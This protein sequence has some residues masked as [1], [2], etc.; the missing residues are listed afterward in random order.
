MNSRKFFA[1]LKRRNVYKVAVAYAIVS[2]LLI[3]AASILFPTFE[4]PPWVMKVFVAV[5][6][7]GF[8]IALVFSWA[9]E[10]TPEGIKREEDVAPNESITRRTGRKIAGITI[11][12]AA[13]A[14]GLVVFQLLRPSLT[15]KGS[16]PAIGGSV[17][18]KSIAVLPF[19]NLSEDKA[20][21]YFASGM[22]DMILTKLAAIGDLK[23]ISRTST[24]RYKSHP[25]DLKT[26]AQQLGVATVLEGSVQKAGEQVL[27]NVQLIDAANDQHLWAD[28]YPRT[29]DNIFGV[30]GEVAEKVA[31]A[32]KAKLAP[33]ESARV[34]SVPT[35]S[36]AALEFYLKGRDLFDRL[37]NSVVSDPIAAGNEAR[38][39]FKSATA[40][41]PDFALAY[42]SWSNLE[43]YLHWYGVDESPEVIDR[44]KICA[45]KALALQPDLAE[46]HFAMG[47]YHY[48]CHRDYKAALDEFAIAEKG[49]PNSAEVLAAIGY[50]H[51][52]QGDWEGGIDRLK[53]AMVIDPRDSLLR[54]EIANSYMSRRRYDEAAIFSAQ[55]LAIAP[56]DMET[57]EQRAASEAFRGNLEAARQFITSI[58]PDKD[59]QG[60]VSH[61]RFKL[62]I[63]QRQPEAALS[64]IAHAPEWLTTRFEHSSAPIELLRGQALK[65]KGDTA[66]ARTQ[67]LNAEAKLKGLL[68]NPE[69]A[70]DANSYLALTYAELGDKEAALQAGR[71]AVQSL[72][73]SRD[74][75]VGSFYLDRLARAEAQVGETQSAIEHIDRLLSASA[76]ATIS[77]ATLRIDPAW[78]PIRQ[79]PRFQALLTKYATPT[80]DSSP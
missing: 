73:V 55:A 19:E 68:S 47:Y 1:E 48:W 6:V 58:P 23:V 80:K 69:T 37:R 7:L 2:W 66:A 18:N 16:P 46:A 20:N 64:A 9:F 79:D 25:D 21:A 17:S 51:R 8:P 70:A 74:A 61:L 59:P 35:K 38:E 34:A 15:S 77:V 63:L 33:A 28:A 75:T 11:A 14:T 36:G 49:M 50:V 31:S 29:L 32:L 41:D 39:M 44:A 67:F 71:A 26:V 3:Q 12:L 56:D 62:A 5:I 54:R 52:R 22:Q 42:V 27:I 30:E 57:I 65:L 78:D 13:V 40:A 76:G 72:P 10:L 60:A 53:K 24:E 43:S 4:A 45:N